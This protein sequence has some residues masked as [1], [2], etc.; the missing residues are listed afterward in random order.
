MIFKVLITIV[1]IAELIITFTILYFLYKFNKRILEIDSTIETVKPQI[2]SVSE[3][4]RK[5]SEQIYELT[6]V[7]VDEIKKTLENLLLEQA[8]SIMTGIL[9][10]TINIKVVKQFRKSKIFKTASKGLSLLQ[11]VI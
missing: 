4:V 3:L 6:P 11:N 2:R 7:W 10:W 5:I 8:K 9:F 1:F